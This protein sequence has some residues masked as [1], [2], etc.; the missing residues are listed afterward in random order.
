VG[1]EGDRLVALVGGVCAVSC[2][3]VRGLLSACTL[4][5]SS[6]PRAVSGRL[7]VSGQAGAE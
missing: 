6:T 3:W 1:A 5:E 4:I 7:A 2:G